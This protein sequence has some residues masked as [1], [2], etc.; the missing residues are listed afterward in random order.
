M[1]AENV[2]VVIPSIPPRTELR[3][4]AVGSV[5][6]QIWQPHE[7]IVPIDYTKQGAAATRNRGLR[8]VTT[9]F[10]AFLDDDDQML[11][12]HLEHLIR[13]QERTGADI[14]YPWFEIVGGEDPLDAFGKPFDAD[15]LRKRNYIPITV[16]ARTQL[17][18]DIGGFKNFPGA[19]WSTCEDW[20][21]WLRL[22]DAGAT[23]VHL[24][25][26][27]WVWHHHGQNTGGRTDK[28]Y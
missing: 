23:F 19:Q 18:Q 12:I 4:R 13:I 16:L 7:V 14:V 24:P 21:T 25:E 6:D 20:Y 10:V 26:K 27:T 3:D 22:L 8:S 5:G 17:L 1:T 11:P 2:T 9:E 28:W 15:E